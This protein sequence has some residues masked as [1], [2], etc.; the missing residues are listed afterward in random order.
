MAN[1]ILFEVEV[2]GRDVVIGGFSTHGWVTRLSAEDNANGSFESELDQDRI[3]GKN[4][5]FIFNLTDNTR[6]DE[7]TSITAQNYLTKAFL[8]EGSQGAYPSEEED[9]QTSDSDKSQQN[10]SKRIGILK[11]GKSAMTIKVSLQDIYNS[12]YRNNQRVHILV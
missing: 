12:V 10:Y 2:G 9:D 1:L 8:V 11:F 4:G 3:Q 5:S 6:L 7:V